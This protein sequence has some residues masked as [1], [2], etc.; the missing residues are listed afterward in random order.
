MRNA[1]GTVIPRLAR[2]NTA[3]TRVGKVISVGT[4]SAVVDVAGIEVTANLL[5][6][7]IPG[8]PV[9]LL[10]DRSR[11]YVLSGGGGGGSFA[12]AGTFT[13]PLDDPGDLPDHYV[14]ILLGPFPVDV[15]V[16]AINGQTINN[17]FWVRGISGPAPLLAGDQFVYRIDYINAQPGGAQFNW[18]AIGT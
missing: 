14:Q 7:V 2:A 12:A 6:P 13:D 9:L 1:I 17:S 5:A 11:W 15:I 18:F 4:N 10:V 3:V 16:S 8:Q